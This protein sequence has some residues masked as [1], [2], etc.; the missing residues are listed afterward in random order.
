MYFNVAVLSKGRIEFSRVQPGRD[1]SGRV[2][3][4]RVGSDQ[5]KNS[6]D[7]GRLG[8]DLCQWLWVWLGGQF[9]SDLHWLPVRHRISFKIATVTYRVLQFQQPYYLAS[10]IPRYV[11]ARAFRSSSS[12][13]ICVPPRKTTMTTSKSFSSVA[14]NI[15][16]AL[17]NL[18]R[19]SQLFLFLEELSNIIYSCLLALTVVRNPVWSNQLD[20][21][22]FV[23]QCQLLPSHSP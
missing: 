20:V 10:L 2:G 17:P 7:F 15:W 5:I 19:P 16:N 12:L 3:L 6:M 22:H 1:E 23:I 18:C 8:Q 4:G 11:P 13:P 21:S 9:L 14:S